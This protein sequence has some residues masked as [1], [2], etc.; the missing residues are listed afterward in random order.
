MTK[1]KCWWTKCY[2]IRIVTVVFSI[3]MFVISALVF[4]SSFEYSIKDILILSL[5]NAVWSGVI[6]A[7][8]YWGATDIISFIHSKTKLK[9]N[10]DT[11]ELKK[12]EKPK[13]LSSDWWLDSFGLRAIG[14]YLIVIFTIRIINLLPLADFS[15]EET[16][17]YFSIL[18]LFVLFPVIIMF[19]TYIV[20]NLISSIIYSIIKN[21]FESKQLEVKTIINSIDELL[22][23]N[24]PFFPGIPIVSYSIF[25]L[26]MD[27]HWNH[28]SDVFI[29][30]WACTVVLS[31]IITLVYEIINICKSKNSK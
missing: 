18:P 22:T 29:W 24:C 9:L 17:Q 11:V 8:V 20:V 15:F 25:L 16:L 31:S 2:C 13:L 14:A 7:F 23:V 4:S 26:L 28:T 12:I 10:N 21:K 1:F 5:M 6:I 19:V 3:I 27:N 30:T